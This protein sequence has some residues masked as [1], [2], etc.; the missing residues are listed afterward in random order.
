MRS[1]D[2]VGALDQQTSQ[3]GV[4]GLRNPELRVPISGLTASR[5]QAEIAPD[6]A[7][8]LKSL[9]AAQSQHERQSRKVATPWTF[10]NACV[11][12]Y[13]V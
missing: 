4:A 8:L 6:I 2:G 10:S 11:S 12:G 1:K 7:A 5:S 9:L 13:C 3:I